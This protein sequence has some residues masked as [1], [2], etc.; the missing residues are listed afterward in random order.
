MTD[1]ARKVIE[2][3]LRAKGFIRV[4]DGRSPDHRWYYLRYGGKD[5]RHITAKISHGSHHKTYGDSL[6]KLM[7]ERLC[8]DSLR[9]VRDLLACPM[10]SEQYL[11]I[12]AGKG[13]LDCDSGDH[14]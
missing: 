3:S 2:R 1:I 4:R 11:E 5:Y 6:L 9:Q 12:L 13:V 14:D 10:D 8:L 7:R